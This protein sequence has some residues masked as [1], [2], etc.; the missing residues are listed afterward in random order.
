MDR[1]HR[2]KSILWFFTGLGLAVAVA[3]YVFGLGATTNL[4]DAVPWGLWIGFD[5][6]SGV[7]LAAGGFVITATVYIFKLE[8]YHSLVRP[9]VLTAL[10]G[11]IAVAVG[12]LFDL[13]LPWNIWHMI[14]YWNF[15]SPLFEVGWCVML[16]LTV[17][18]LEFFPVP[19]EDIGWLAGI[20]RSLV[21]I[22]LPLVIAG[23][24]L[25]T[26]HQ[27]SLGSL[28]LIVPYNLPPLWYSPILP[29][30]FFI[31]AVGLGLLMVTLESL[32][33]SWL[34][35]RS[36]EKDLL[37]GI[38]GA[39]R[40]VILVY[41][42]V[43]FLDLALR[44]Q[45]ELIFNHDWRTMMFWLEIVLSMI[46]PLVLLFIP[47]VRRSLAGLWSVAISGVLGVVLNRI[48]VGGLVHFERGEVFYLPLWIE[49]AISAAIV[50]VA[51]LVFL[52]MVERFKVWE[53]PPQISSDESLKQ[54]DSFPYKSLWQ[55]K[56]SSAVRACYSLGFIIASAL[57]FMF[58][59]VNTAEYRGVL[60]TPVKEARGGDI[61]WI[62]GNRD[63]FGT[64]FDHQM[65]AQYA[66]MTGSCAICH[67]MNLPDDKQSRCSS[68]HQMMYL[69]TDAFNHNW[70]Y[71]P[72][73]AGLPC[74]T[75]HESGQ[76]KSNKTIKQCDDCHKDLIPQSAGVVVNSYK[77]PPYPQ[78]MHIMC[79][80]CHSKLD[81]EYSKPR[82][83]RCA[84]C[85][86]DRRFELIKDLDTTRFGLPT[87]PILPP[88]KK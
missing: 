38:T 11:Y 62:D 16:Y 36:P 29:I 6:M 42:I 1:I 86:N 31:S 24:A 74:Y 41:C 68:C 64:R 18:L 80:T 70:H 79:I 75:C 65:H 43:R 57:G 77:A 47:K 56:P 9:A 14:I 20:R 45:I 81:E 13:G 3:R 19:A 52:F 17:L 84:A 51:I 63:G 71:S 49:I 30:N 21:K 85:H 34:Y 5:V 53:T 87:N 7:A 39:A 59:T 88:I 8:K 32:V 67:H 10:L 28:F 22:R 44:G 76:P 35:R 58:I 60:K 12:L 4:S 66:E 27:S 25:S 23:I 55:V 82:L 78:A 50:S 46:I 61:L 26:L 2:F 40:W 83:A 72:K 37:I 54:I 48:N 33:S 69:P 73:G 15:H